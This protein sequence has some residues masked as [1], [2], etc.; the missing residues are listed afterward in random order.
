MCIRDSHNFD[1]IAT[2]DGTI[3]WE[4]VKNHK[5]VICFGKPWY[6]LMPGVFEASKVNDLNQILSTKWTLEDINK[7]FT[8]LTKKMAIGYVCH[9]ETGTVNSYD[10]FTNYNT[11]SSEQKSKMLLNNDKIVAESFY[12]I[13]KNIKSNNKSGVNK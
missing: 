13:I 3:G 10:E 11:L 12:N 8:E 2:I 1:L 5:P 4:A 6:L 9:L 7:K